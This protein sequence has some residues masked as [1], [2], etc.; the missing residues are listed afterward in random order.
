MEPDKEELQKSIDEMYPEEPVAEDAPEEVIEKVEDEKSKDEVVADAKPEAKPEV[1]FESQPIAETPKPKKSKKALVFV[2]VLAIVLLLAA[3]A[4]A[5]W[6]FVFNKPA[7]MNNGGTT[8]NNTVATETD[9]DLLKM[10]TPTTGET[11]L[12]APVAIDSQGLMTAE[13]LNP[14]DQAYIDY[15]QVGSRAGNEIIAVSM[16]TPGMTATYLF[17]RSPAGVFTYISRPDGL[18]VYN[19]Q[20]ETYSAQEIVS[21]VVIDKAIHYDTL[22]I[23]KTFTLD[24]K[25]SVAMAPTSPTVGYFYVS[26]SDYSG[27]TVTVTHTLVKQLGKNALMKSESLNITTGLI[28]VGYFIKTALNTDIGLRYE[29]L[30]VSLL[31]YQWSEGTQWTTGDSL[32]AMTYGC[33]GFGS[34]IVTKSTALTDADVKTV[35]KSGNGLTVYGFTSMDNPLLIKAY[36]EY[37][38]AAQYDMVSYQGGLIESISQFADQHAVVLFKDINNQWLVYARTQ[39]SP[40]GACAKP[41]VYL[42]PA[43]AQTVRVKVGADVKVSD[44]LY[45]PAT[46]W[47]AFA[48]P[49]GQLTVN[50]TEYGSLFWE[51]PG[52]G[53][54]PSISGGTVVRQ[55][56]VI[57][58]IRQQLAEQGLNATETNEFVDYWQDQIP[59]KPYVRLTWF[60]TAQMNQL[61]PLYI[62][63]KPDTMI[64]V[65]LDMGGLDSPISIPAQNLTSIPRN[66]FTVVEWGGLSSKKLY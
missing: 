55:S 10:I 6:Y 42:Y 26:P 65:F 24:D 66:G 8:Q 38:Q 28:S 54:Y 63:P 30:D 37:K 1:K 20:T 14:T 11:W 46:G 58:T 43:T 51:G 41:V 40:Q 23:P 39:L 5:V 59:N 48:Q 4:G 27:P 60:N 49:N 45:N 17:E 52:Y 25:G 16:P 18:A 50:G 13:I 3:G 31:N 64:R 61:A 47:T 62:S 2:V 22:S 21:T 7:V 44:P 53:Q 32:K 15:F 29:P 33:G 19:E 12:P 34:S 9:P 57:S 36:D 35:G 56:D